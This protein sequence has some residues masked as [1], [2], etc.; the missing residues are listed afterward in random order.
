MYTLDHPLV[1][2]AR[3]I[4]RAAEGESVP[5]GTWNVYLGLTDGPISW[6]Q[7]E[8]VRAAIDEAKSRPASALLKGKPARRPLACVPVA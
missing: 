4:E 7:F 5:E 1:L 2:L 3:Q 6:Q 8:R